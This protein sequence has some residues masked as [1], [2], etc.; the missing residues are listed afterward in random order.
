[1]R[2]DLLDDDQQ[3][4]PRPP[5]NESAPSA[6]L[7]APY[8][9]L[10][11]SIYDA[12]LITD[13]DGTVVEANARAA[14]FFYV[15]EDELPGQTVQHFI[16]GVDDAVLARLREELQAERFVL[17]Q[18]NCLRSDRSLFPAEIS[19]NLIRAD[20]PRIC[21]F[22][23]DV[24]LRRKQESE[25]RIGSMAIQNAGNGIAICDRDGLLTKVNPAWAQ[26]WGYDQPA[27][28]EGLHFT[29]L[30]VR[31]TA[32][33]DMLHKV[34]EGTGIWKGELEARHRTGPCFP[35]QVSTASNYDQRGTLIG[36]VISAD[37]ISERKRI[38]E[39]LRDRVHEL[40]EN[41][42]QQTE[43]LIQA[44]RL[45]TLGTLVAGIAHEINNPNT[46][47]ASNIA[48]FRVMWAIM[49]PYLQ[50]WVK[51]EPHSDHRLSLVLEEM[52]GLM[53]GMQEGSKRIATIIKEMKQFAAG[54]R[55]PFRRILPQQVIDTA[56]VFARKNIESQGIKLTVNLD[57]DIPPIHGSETM[58]SQV[59]INLL[60]NA[61]HSFE[62]H[63]PNATARITIGGERIAPDRIQIRV[64]D[65]GPGISAANVT[66]LFDPFFTTRRTSSGTGLG[67]FVCHAIITGHGGRIM[68]QSTEGEQTTFTIELPCLQEEGAH[69]ESHI[70]EK[71]A[72]P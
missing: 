49:E 32:L 35:A 66:Q 14:S 11:Q 18:A 54:N 6:P 38:Q 26:Q 15:E 33:D 9:E 24:T 44:D 69:P 64:T 30:F 39:A 12:V 28:V 37:D 10:L 7:N 25:L 4:S 56:L 70:Q 57:P 20:H 22:I 53:N 59:F 17:L 41:L 8:R 65:N 3:I 5:S 36:L 34:F 23:R 13:F 50:E 43:R 40:D 71:G 47:I 45:A 46:F 51:S 1:M 21:F 31:S 2:I 16:V 60:I 42:K 58:L 55:I 72:G 52:P 29:S 48:T 61:L 62:A 63:P 67:L 68:V 27:E 19:A